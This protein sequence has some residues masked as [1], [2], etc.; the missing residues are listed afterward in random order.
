MDGLNMYGG[1]SLRAGL[2]DEWDDLHFVHSFIRTISIY[3]YKIV[4][5]KVFLIY[6]DKLGII[7][8]YAS[9]WGRVLDYKVLTVFG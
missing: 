7:D 1:L 4:S 6:Y 8:I 2:C 5:S 3:I 9:A